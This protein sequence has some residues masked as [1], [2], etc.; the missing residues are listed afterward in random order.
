L[1]VKDQ[2]LGLLVAEDRNGQVDV[3]RRARFSPS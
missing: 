3:A 1:Q 2:L